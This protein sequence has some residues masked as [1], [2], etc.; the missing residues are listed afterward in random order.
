[1]HFLTSG[2]MRDIDF[3]TSARETTWT[4]VIKLRSGVA[5]GYTAVISTP[6]VPM[7]TVTTLLVATPIRIIVSK[8]IFG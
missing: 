8:H 1:M 5:P 6:A 7:V 4:I 3:E 2:T